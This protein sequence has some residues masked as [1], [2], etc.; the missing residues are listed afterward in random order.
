MTPGPGAVLRQIAKTAALAG[1]LGLLLYLGVT[2]LAEIEGAQ[3]IIGLVLA[4]P[5]TG[6]VGWIVWD[7]LRSGIFPMR[8]SSP[9]RQGEPVAYW[10]SVVWFAACG[11]M[12]AA[13][14]GWCVMRLLAG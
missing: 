2:W 13:L 11:V 4:A 7:A 8:F 12:L 10:C 14:A 5:M 6:F 3:W 9:T 1:G